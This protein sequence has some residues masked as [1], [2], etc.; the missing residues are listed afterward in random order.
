MNIVT[1]LSI[2]REWT[3]AHYQS[4]RRER[5]AEKNGSDVELAGTRFCNGG[6]HELRGE[7]TQALPPWL[8]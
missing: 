4:H 1:D 5:L 8:Q 7:R 6:P 2:G 3:R